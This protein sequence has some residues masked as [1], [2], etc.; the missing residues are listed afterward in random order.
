M[1][2]RKGLINNYYI[3]L[4]ELEKEVQSDEFKDSKSE[5]LMKQIEDLKNANIEELSD[6]TIE[7]N[8]IRMNSIIYNLKVLKKQ[9]TG[10][11]GIKMDA[12]AADKLLDDI[13][14]NPS[15][16]SYDEILE[17][18]EYCSNAIVHD[19]EDV[20]ID[21]RIPDLSE[22][23]KSLYKLAYK[24]ISI[25]NVLFGSSKLLKLLG[26]ISVEELVNS[27]VLELTNDEMSN[28]DDRL[29]GLRIYAQNAKKNKIRTEEIKHRE[30]RSVLGYLGRDLEDII[31]KIKKSEDKTVEYQNRTKNK[32]KE[33][34]FC[35]GASLLFLVTSFLTVKE[36]Q[37]GNSTYKV[38]KETYSTIDNNTTEET[39]LENFYGLNNDPESKIFVIDYDKYNRGQTRSRVVKGPYKDSGAMLIYFTTPE[40]ESEPSEEVHE[41]INL[42]EKDAKINLYE[43]VY[44]EVE[45]YTYEYYGD[46]ENEKLIRWIAFI[47]MALI[48]ATLFERLENFEGISLLQEALSEFEH[49]KEMNMKQLND[50]LNRITN[51]MVKYEEEEKVLRELV[52]EKI[53]LLDNPMLLEEKL[54]EIINFKEYEKGQAMIKKHNKK[55]YE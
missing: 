23:L 52:G 44:T 47:F 8:N 20:T 28:L 38:N 14:D 42:E 16:F 25:E 53:Y 22:I 2:S 55:R 43:D 40:F 37:K 50:C 10:S 45:R 49:D 39:Y 41:E 35:Y 17:R 46:I 7:K 4:Q 5:L 15:N 12:M 48:L 54:D 29:D 24:I 9:K 3:L 26:D 13:I 21:N 1:L 51:E 31:K 27:D 36:V 6:L 33:K 34:L 30:T 11:N 18:I 32:I 19:I